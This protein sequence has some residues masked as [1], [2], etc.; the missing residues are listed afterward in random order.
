MEAVYYVPYFA[1]LDKETG[2]TF[3]GKTFYTKEEFG[4]LYD[5]VK[6]IYEKYNITPSTNSGDWAWQKAALLHEAEK[7]LLADM[8]VI[9][10]LFNKNAVL[11]SGELSGV[12]GTYYAPAVFQH[13]TLN[14]YDNYTYIVKSKDAAGNLTEEKHSVFA[15]FPE[16][17]WSKAGTVVEE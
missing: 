15:Y 10:V 6:G 12:W 9:P 5:T 3:L 1:S 16:I 13:T 2:Y 11:Q 8:P 17:D 7:L 14:N 4:K